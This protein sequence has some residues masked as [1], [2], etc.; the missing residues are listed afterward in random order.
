MHEHVYTDFGIMG[1]AVEPLEISGLC[2]A[3]L[4]LR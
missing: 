4:G 3:M 2:A 1:D